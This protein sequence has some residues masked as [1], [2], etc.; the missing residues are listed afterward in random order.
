MRST[1][2]TRARLERERATPHELQGVGGWLLFFLFGITFLSP[3][4]T[5]VPYFLTNKF[6][7]GGFVDVAATCLGLLA[8]FFL[9]QE[10][11]EG[12]DLLRIYFGVSSL[13]AVVG[14]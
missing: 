8:A 11:P 9:W 5:I 14:L 13:L 6:N 12:L 1:F 3:L 4:Q 2:S 10:H 7:L